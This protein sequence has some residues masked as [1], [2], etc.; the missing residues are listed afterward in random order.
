MKAEPGFSGILCNYLKSRVIDM[1]NNNTLPDI[2]SYPEINSSAHFD[3][4]PPASPTGLPD[5]AY[6]TSAA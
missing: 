4:L 2:N 5:S 6:G 1:C 3:L